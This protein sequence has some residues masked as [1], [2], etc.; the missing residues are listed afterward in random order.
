MKPALLR[1]EKLNAAV[2]EL[3]LLGD[4][5]KAAV[6]ELFLLEDKDCV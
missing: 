2:E 3:F 5:L 1:E 6:E 4:K